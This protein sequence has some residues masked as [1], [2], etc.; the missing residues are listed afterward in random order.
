MID[1]S[2]EEKTGEL[3][4]EIAIRE[5]YYAKHAE[6]MP[7][8]RKEQFKRRIEIIKAILSDYQGEQTKADARPLRGAKATSRG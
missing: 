8:R 7:P 4:I 1:I 5:R 2:H 3:I 6:M